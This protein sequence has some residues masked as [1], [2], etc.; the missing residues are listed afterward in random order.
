MKPLVLGLLL[1]PLSA[2]AADVETLLSNG[3]ADRR[4]DL[5]IMGD[6]Y[7]DTEQTKLHD[8]AVTLTT[9]LFSLTPYKEYQA[10]F[11]VRLVH[12]ISNQTGADNGTYGALRDTALGAYF[13]CAQIDRLLCVDTAAVYAQANL[14]APSW[15]VIVVLVND[16]KYGGSG[17]TVSVISSN[18]S[19]KEIFSHEL[20]HTLGG[21]ADEYTTAYPGYAPCVTECPEPNASLNATRATV[22]W[23]PWI[24]LATPVPSPVGTPGI[25]VFDGCRY[26]THDVYRPTD[27]SC[28]M[29]LLGQPYCSVCTE[30]LILSLWERSSP[31]EDARPPPMNEVDVTPCASQTF[32]FATPQVAS[33]GGF[34]WTLD[35]QT[36]PSTSTTFTL[37]T[38]SLTNGP[39]QVT[40]TVH[41]T[42]ALVRNDPSRMLEATQ[43]WAVVADSCGGSTGGGGGSTG[44][45]STGGGGSDSDDGGSTGGGSSDSGS[46]GEGG[47]A[48]G[49]GDG[50]GAA[51]GGLQSP[52]SLR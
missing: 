50:D 14:S 20:G 12:V 5:V 21:L 3:P 2:V 49:V 30:G 38:A 22:K 46:T 25:G 32:S 13:N 11:N 45:G 44:G 42:T 7:L 27:Q 9:Y 33:L 36:Q 39:H 31:I 35:G 24:D 41:D 40:V 18:T 34:V 15:D 17:G 23:A 16:P 43:I 52:V 19:A 8:D 10:L 26:R 47:G 51:G 29:N 28:M 1:L 48:S 6:G 4:I 37:P